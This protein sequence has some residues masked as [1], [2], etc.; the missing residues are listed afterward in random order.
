M[1]NPRTWLGLG[2]G[3]GT[4]IGFLIAT[5]VFG[6]LKWVQ[7]GIQRQF[8]RAIEDLDAKSGRISDLEQAQNSDTQRIAGLQM[9]I[10]A[11]D[12][13]I[14]QLST[15]ALHVRALDRERVIL[16]QQVQQQR[17]ELAQLP[18]LREAEREVNHLRPVMA[19]ITQLRN[20]LDAK[21][22][23]ITQLQ[24]DHARLRERVTR[25]ADQLDFVKQELVNKEEELEQLRPPA[26]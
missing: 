12:A 13:E 9:E 3:L 18:N 14:V 11:K 17:D 25:L 5:W 22:T 26:R 7:G 15:Q 24:E 19:E 20:T 2:I 8:S 10:R 1:M 23:T 6:V 21:D 4:I 16:E